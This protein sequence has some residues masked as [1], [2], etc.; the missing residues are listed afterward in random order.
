MDHDKKTLPAGVQPYDALNGA[1]V[2]AL[3]GGVLTALLAAF[4]SSP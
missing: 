3:A 4:D 1:R 2:G